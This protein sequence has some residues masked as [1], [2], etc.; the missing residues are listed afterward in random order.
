M[1]AVRL[2]DHDEAPDEDHIVVLHN[3]TW[4]DYERIMRIR[5]EH[6][7]P[8]ISF[9]EGELEI[10]SPSKTHESI[11]RR[12]GRLVEDWC[13]EKGIRFEPV[14][15]WTI[16]Q[17]AKERGAEPD[18]CFV[19]GDLESAERPDLAIEVVWTSGGIDRLA[20][21][22][23]LGVREVWYWRRGTIRVYLLR[24]GQYREHPTSKALAG[25]DLKALA[26]HVELP[27]NKAISAWRSFISR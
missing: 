14:G 17:R 18:E 1:A 23:E 12:I 15:Q 25:M 24:S 7:G 3:A 20:I 13:V 22:R 4:A 8:Q 27:T 5:G 11:K 21:Y 10:M 19:F 26:R 6:S 9:L 2:A 16:K